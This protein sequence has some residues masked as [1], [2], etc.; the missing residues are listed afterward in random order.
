M[1]FWRNAQEFISTN[2]VTNV[3]YVLCTTYLYLNKTVIRNLHHKIS[4]ANFCCSILDRQV[5]TVWLFENL[6][7]MQMLIK[8]VI[9]FERMVCLIGMQRRE[10]SMTWSFGNG[11]PIV[12][13][14]V[15]LLKVRKN[16]QWN[17]FSYKTS[18]KNPLKKIVF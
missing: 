5:Y 15:G 9:Q 4:P 6:I 14:R 17:G 2:N 8:W 16:T 10:I 18:L 1:D 7:D 13:T 3:M 11:L 12:R